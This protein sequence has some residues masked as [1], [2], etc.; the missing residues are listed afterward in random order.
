MWKNPKYLTA[1]LLFSSQIRKRDWPVDGVPL[2]AK[3]NV[4]LQIA[5]IAAVMQHQLLLK[6]E[7][8]GRLVRS[9]SD[10]RLPK[11]P[12]RDTLSLLMDL[13]DACITSPWRRL[14]S[15]EVLVGILVSGVA[16][17]GASYGSQ[18]LRILLLRFK[19]LLLAICG[20]VGHCSEPSL[21]FC[22][23]HNQ[24]VLLSDVLQPEGS[25][26]RG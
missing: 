21:P 9:H 5:Q 17:V 12:I 3:M 4:K 10:G 11:A 7:Y 8:K 16:K 20:Q 18:M 14:K 19:T 22:L 25:T 13:A 2:L 6:P 23:T 26:D 24:A 15:C 1:C